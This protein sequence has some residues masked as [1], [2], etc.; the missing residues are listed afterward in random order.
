MWFSAG[1]DLYTWG[2][3]AFHQLGRDTAQKHSTLPVSLPKGKGRFT[4]L[5][6]CIQYLCSH[7]NYMCL[8]GMMLWVAVL[9]LVA[10]HIT[11]ACPHKSYCCKIKKKDFCHNKLSGGFHLHNSSF[12]WGH[13]DVRK[14]KL[15]AGFISYLIDFKLAVIGARLCTKCFLWLWIFLRNC[16]GEVLQTFLFDNAVVDR[17]SIVLC[18]CHVRFWMS[19]C[20]NWLICFVILFWCPKADNCRTSNFSAFNC[21]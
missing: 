20:R 10:K 16:L 6:K 4:D 21:F 7:K 9:P 8:F 13:R 11:L 18:S 3:N 14:V 17:F 2:S 19:D 5:K 12:K 1:G 15:Q